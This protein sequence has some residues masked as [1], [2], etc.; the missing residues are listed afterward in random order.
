[1][2][3]Y[4]AA[5][6]SPCKAGR[7]RANNSAFPAC[8]RLG[9]EPFQHAAE[10]GQCPL[11]LKQPLGGQLVGRLAI[12]AALGVE[13]VDRYDRDAAAAFG[14]PIVVATIGQVVLA[15]RPEERAE[16][17][18]RLVQARQVAAFEKVGEEALDDILGLIR[19]TTMTPDKGVER[20]PV[21]AAQL[22]QCRRGRA[23][24]PDRRRE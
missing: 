6:V 5:R 13:P 22:L 16:P 9:L 21:I 10:Q 17:A 3:A 19:R 12:V 8:N 24:R 1:M 18:L 4:D 7:S 14:G 2:A 11:P 20:E 15:G 23:G